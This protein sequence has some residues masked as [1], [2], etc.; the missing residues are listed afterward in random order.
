LARRQQEG[1]ETTRAR[2]DSPQQKRRRQ[3]ERKQRVLHTVR[4]MRASSAMSVAHPRDR[5]AICACSPAQPAQQPCSQMM[6]VCWPGGVG[7]ERRSEQRTATRKWREA[8]RCWVTPVSALQSRKERSGHEPISRRAAYER[9]GTASL[10]LPFVT[11]LPLSC[12]ARNPSCGNGSKSGRSGENWAER[13]PPALK[14]LEMNRI[15]L[16]LTPRKPR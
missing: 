2:A 3:T 8:E 16:H 15:L 5:L 10:S 4:I 11:P 1:A 9:T 12:R 6:A 13:G 14:T 7:G